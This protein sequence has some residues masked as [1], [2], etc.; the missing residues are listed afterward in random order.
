M[1]DLL[2]FQILTSKSI[3]MQHKRPSHLWLFVS[4]LI[5]G[6]DLQGQTPKTLLWE[7]SGNGLSESSYLYGTMHVADKRAYKFR[8]SV[9]PSFEKCK[10]FAMELDME[11]VNPL[12]MMNSMK[13]DSGKL[14]DFFQ[15][16]DYA[17]LSS[18]FKENMRTDIALFEDF[19]PFFLYSLMAKDQYGSQMDEA[20][21]LY[22]Y[23]EAKKQGKSTGGLETVA[24]QMNAINRIPM[25]D[26]I[27]MIMEGMEEEG[28]SKDESQVLIKYYKKQDLDRMMS[29]SEEMEMGNDFEAAL[30]TERNYR[31]A[32]RIQPLIKEQSTFIAVGALHLPGQEGVIDLLRKDGYEVNPIMK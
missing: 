7:I 6:I 21:D 28:D 32:E 22:F 31:M 15:K 26:Q 25:D 24:E 2:F 13:L 30:I 29:L 8:K 9:M 23:K 14:S 16:D 17:K 19:K 3:Y 12:E 11:E 27:K 20:L 4:F 5:L 1:P 18:W 10:G